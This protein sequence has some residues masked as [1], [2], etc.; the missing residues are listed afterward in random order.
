MLFCTEEHNLGGSLISET[1]TDFKKNKEF[2]FVTKALLS[3]EI[4]IRAQL[5][6]CNFKTIKWN[7]AEVYLK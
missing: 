3:L 6:C 7:K 5:S 1:G 4:Q 2:F